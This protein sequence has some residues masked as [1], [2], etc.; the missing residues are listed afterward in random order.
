MAHEH[1]RGHGHAEGMRALSW[2]LGINLLLSVVQIAG[3]VIAGSLA[4]VADALHNLSDAGALGV[5]LVARSWAARAPDVQR[6]YGYGRAELIGAMVNFTILLMVSIYLGYEAILRWFS[7][8]PVSGGIVIAI[9][10]VA[11]AVDLAT[12][13]LTWRHSKESA[14]I[15]AAFLHNVADALSSVAVIVAGALIVTYGWMRADAVCTLLVAA[16]VFRHTL[17]ELRP[18]VGVLMQGTPAGIDVEDLVHSMQ[19]VESVLEVHHLHVWQVDEH[20]RS[21]EAHI[22]IGEATLP[23]QERVK[24]LIKEL[25]AARF[26]ITHSTLEFEYAGSAACAERGHGGCHDFRSVGSDGGAGSGHS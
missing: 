23:E 1:H 6:S 22:V 12:A 2:A 10:V 21:L 5:A 8:G 15:R 18:V 20:S 3:G 7:P 26:N 25:I 17:K 19:Q 24:A 14:N 11:L 16:W 4:L 13:A 9:A